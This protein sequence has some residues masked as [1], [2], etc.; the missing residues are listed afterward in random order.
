MIIGC[1]TKRGG[2]SASACIGRRL[3]ASLSLCPPES[4]QQRRHFGRYQRLLWKP[5]FPSDLPPALRQ[6]AAVVRHA[7]PEVSPHKTT[8]TIYASQRIHEIAPELCAR[9]AVQELAANII[10][11]ALAAIDCRNGKEAM[12][13]EQDFRSDIFTACSNLFEVHHV[14]QGAE[15]VFG[16]LNEKTL[17]D[18]SP[19]MRSNKRV[20]LN[21]MVLDSIEEW[22]SL[23]THSFSQINAHGLFEVVGPAMFLKLIPRLH[24]S[25]LALPSEDLEVIFY[26]LETE[27]PD[28]FGLMRVA[29]SLLPVDSCTDALG[30]T[31]WTLRRVLRLIEA[32]RSE[33]ALRFFLT[34]LRDETLLREALAAL[35]ERDVDTGLLREK[36]SYIVSMQLEA[37]T[38]TGRPIAVD[39][40]NMWPMLHATPPPMQVELSSLDNDLEV[41]RG[42]RLFLTDGELRPFEIKRH[43]PRPLA[44]IAEPSRFR[45]TPWPQL[46]FD[47]AEALAV[48]RGEIE[49][50]SA[51]DAY[52]VIAGRAED[53]DAMQLWGGGPLAETRPS[54]SS[55]PGLP[56]PQATLPL[57]AI[58]F[59]DSVQA[60]S[61]VLTF[62]QHTPP[63][64]VGMD[65]EWA[66]P[67]PVSIIQLATPT[68]AFVIDAV[69]R[70]PL[71]MSVL[72][73][74]VDWLLKR[75]GT[76][77][78]FFG[79]PHDLLRLNMLFGPMGKS[80]SGG[81]HI[82]S[83]VDLYM[84]RIQ[85]VPVRTPRKAD[86]PMG[87][88]ELLGE[89]MMDD[90]FEK[91][92]RLSAITPPH[93]P[94]EDVAEKVYTVGGHHSL[95][96]MA[97]RHLGE[98]LDKRYRASNWNFRPLAAAQ[99]VYA[100]TDAHI[101]L[102]LESAMRSRGILPQ[103]EWGCGPRDA[104]QPAWWRQVE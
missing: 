53:V 48:D 27:K 104:L 57:D 103:R 83:V 41:P 22:V 59:V 76:T 40:P 34:N 58:H 93:P 64:F 80:F 21:D 66:D 85:R 5:A 2:P 86:T 13:R 87:R 91:V 14:H 49:P 82:A 47:P 52:D 11:R 74:L 95:S 69:N 71:Y 12:R 67:H 15:V 97:A 73:C 3:R 42:Q 4:G 28:I 81:D 46:A 33:H 96:S 7:A 18:I 35:R 89:A 94:R 26:H 84:Q 9:G 77:K 23:H 99:V 32:R 92:R 75:E 102:R 16:V 54:T 45:D 68:R 79:F 70:T 10:Y 31:T 17:R 61:H 19:E 65:L 24:L 62:L 8:W 72:H 78:L 51:V 20:L 38:H 30:G 63:E 60:L 29:V 44:G 90:D 1:T 25:L 43:T 101:L 56:S 36:W 50:S 55:I 88:E 6:N 39:M 37:D 100:A 98:P